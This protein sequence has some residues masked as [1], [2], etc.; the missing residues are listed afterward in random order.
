MNNFDHVILFAAI[1]LCG[2]LVRVL[3]IR[4]DGPAAFTVG[5]KVGIV[6]GSV[7]M[8]A[9]GGYM[10]SST[11]MLAKYQDWALDKW[12]S[13]VCG[14][15]AQDLAMTLNRGVRKASDGLLTRVLKLSSDKKPR[16]P[17]E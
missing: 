15:G 3:L 16:K 12:T 14:F 10:V 5:Q 8:A 9:L 2:A 13:C 4:A 1:G 17:M 11:P 6:I 7:C